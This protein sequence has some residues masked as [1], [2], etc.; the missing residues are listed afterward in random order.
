MEAQ[1]KGER[2]DLMWVL[3][4]SRWLQVKTRWWGAEVE[5]GS[6]GEEAAGPACVAAGVRWEVVGY[7]I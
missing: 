1:R 7:Q 3:A 2:H 4:E 5:A 6:R